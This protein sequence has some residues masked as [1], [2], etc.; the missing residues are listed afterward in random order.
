M[1]FYAPAQIVRDAR[2]HGIEVRPIDVNH[3]RWDCTLEPTAGRWMAVR[4]GLRY[5]R[6]LSNQDGAAIVLARG[7]D[8][9]TSVEEIQ[10]RAGVSGRALD[11][12]G[13]ARGFG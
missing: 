13:H 8:P 11:R 1:G 4:M 3:S 5:A 6:E 10:R 12:I 9:Y 7:G 2:N